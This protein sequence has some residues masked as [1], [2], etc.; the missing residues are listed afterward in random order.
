MSLVFVF[1]VFSPAFSQVPVSDTTTA[2]EEISNNNKTGKEQLK[3]LGSSENPLSGVDTSSQD[4]GRINDSET[5]TN[6]FLTQDESVPK[7]ELPDESE[8]RGIDFL[9]ELSAG[10]SLPQFTIEP[11]NIST[12]GEPRFLVSSGVI[13]PFARL[14]YTGISVRYLQL[15][16]ELEKSNTTTVGLYPF[17]TVKTVTNELMGFLSVPV[18]IGMRFEIGI[19]TPYFYANI[20]P[21]Y[22][23]SGRQFGITKTHTV[24]YDS[25]EIIITEI[26]DIETTDYRERHQVFI[27]GG[28][29]IDISYGYGSIF[30]EGSCQVG[31]FDTDEES[32]NDISVPKRTSS[33]LIYF[34]IS[35]GIKFYL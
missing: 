12:K 32:G 5:I 7:I 24:D 34:P 35:V 17:T 22:L 11:D 6:P 29:G 18:K 9:I 19:A 27:G 10:V 16:F 30:I 3:D 31:I 33:S 15:S 13:V 4:E 26:K 14:F 8:N 28:I 20:E 1:P 23:T 2:I 25:S 21:A